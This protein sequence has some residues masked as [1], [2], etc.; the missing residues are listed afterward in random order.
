MGHMEVHGAEGKLKSRLLGLTDR[1]EK[2]GGELGLFGARV[3][4]IY[5]G[6]DSREGDERM[7]LS[8]D[9]SLMIWLSLSYLQCS[10]G[11]YFICS[12]N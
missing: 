1:E 8:V 9:S 11:C 12:G 5:G 4:P 3:R 10:I 7:R 2:R 6:R